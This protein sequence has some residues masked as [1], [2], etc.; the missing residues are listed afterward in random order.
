MNAN[1]YTVFLMLGTPKSLMFFSS[2]LLFFGAEW[3]GGVQALNN[4]SQWKVSWSLASW[5]WDHPATF[6]IPSLLIDLWCKTQY[7]K[8]LSARNPHPFSSPAFSVSASLM[9][10]IIMM[11]MI[12]VVIMMLMII[13]MWMMLFILMMRMTLLYLY[14]YHTPW[15]LNSSPVKS[16]H[17]KRK[18]VSKTVIFRGLRARCQ[19]RQR[20]CPRR[21]W[22][23][24]LQW[25]TV[26]LWGGHPGW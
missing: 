4:P 2:E 16:Y 12:G 7:W 13:R 1:Y 15:N 21:C 6:A 19:S 25:G 26:F 22:A 3:Q 5:K 17:P 9:T 23:T 8:P 14:H 20:Q 11:T 24:S 18:V 10:S